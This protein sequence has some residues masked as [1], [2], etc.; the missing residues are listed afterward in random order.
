MAPA[1]RHDDPG[2]NVGECGAALAF[3]PE[4]VDAERIGAL[5]DGRLRGKKRRMVVAE[6]ATSEEAV[7]VFADT[8]EIVNGQELGADGHSHMERRPTLGAPL[9]PLEA[10]RLTVVYTDNVP[11]RTAGEEAES[12]FRPECDHTTDNGR[13]GGPPPD[14][15]DDAQTNIFSVPEGIHTIRRDA[16]AEIRRSIGPLSGG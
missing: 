5:V 13:A 9:S 15:P 8:A 16:A 10:A 12:A 4:Y 7:V 6:I 14:E 2:A 11:S 3:R 1:A